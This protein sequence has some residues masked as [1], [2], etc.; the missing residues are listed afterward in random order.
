MLIKKRKSYPPEELFMIANCKEIKF[1]LLGR[2]QCQV[3]SLFRSHEFLMGPCFFFLVLNNMNSTESFAY[4]NLTTLM[5]DKPCKS[6]VIPT[7]LSSDTSIFVTTR[8]RR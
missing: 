5:L 8:G 6:H 1:E 3:V 2:P 7:F 4:V